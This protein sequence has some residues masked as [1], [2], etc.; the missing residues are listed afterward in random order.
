MLEQSR[1]SLSSELVLRGVCKSL[2]HVDVVCFKFFREQV[3]IKN[4]YF[5]G[6]RVAQC[7]WL[8]S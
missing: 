8:R 6:S 4:Y 1:L 7:L 2:S 3:A 5:R